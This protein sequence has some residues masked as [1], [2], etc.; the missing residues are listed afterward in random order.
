M[1][2]YR[3]AAVIKSVSDSTSGLALSVKEASLSDQAP[4][5]VGTSRRLRVATV[6][7]RGVRIPATALEAMRGVLGRI[8]I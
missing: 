5:G 3:L 7:N 4:E 1:A 6:I 8:L 2:S